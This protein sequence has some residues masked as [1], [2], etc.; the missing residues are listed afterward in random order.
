M[1]KRKILWY[2]L[3]GLL[4]IVLA[5]VVSLSGIWIKY[6]IMDYEAISVEPDSRDYSTYYNSLNY[7]DQ[8]LYNSVVDAATEIADESEILNYSY[9]MEVFMNV[10]GC[11]RADRP[12]LFS[13]DFEALVLQ[14]SNHK[15]K[16]G[17]VYLEEQDVIT[18][19]IA[20][21][22]DAVD[23]A[24]EKVLPSMTDYEK[25]LTINDYLLDHCRYAP[26]ERQQIS[27]TAYGALV[28][29]EA[30]CDG[31]AYAAKQLLDK[32][33]IDSVIIYGETEG[34]MHVWNMVQIEGQYYHLDVMWN[35]ADI[36]DENKLRFHGYFNL[37][38]DVSKL[39]H[40]YENKDIIPY[41]VSDVNYYKKTGCY[42]ETVEGIEEVLYNQLKLAVEQKREY[43]ELLCPETK[44]SEDIEAPYMAALKRVNEELGSDVLYEVFSIYD[45]TARDNSITIQI[46]YN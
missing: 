10:V 32:A 4:I 2:C 41:A 31:Y 1:D 22:D 30:Y 17:M 12:E 13:V 7:K 19:M 11:I 43:I 38:D 42:A 26:G 15:T 9:D 18:D 27:S 36:G 3:F 28:L 8:L 6:K 5:V 39:D 40:N 20:K 44:S 37:S 24:M 33:Y 16:V 35:D 14:H 25:E 45:A 34:A 21:Y 23:S 29:G 46:F